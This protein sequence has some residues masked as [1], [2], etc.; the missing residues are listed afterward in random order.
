MPFVAFYHT[1]K[2]VVTLFVLIY[3]IKAILLLMGNKDTLGRFNKIVK[4]PEMVI[5]LLFFATGLVML[6]R[7]ANFN[8]LFAIKLTLVILSIPL[9]VVAYRK[10]NK[11]M[12]VFAVFM[13]LSAYGLAE[14]YKAQFAKKHEVTNVVTD[15][16]AAGYDLYKHGA[17]LFKVQC[18]VCHGED[19]KANLSGAKD[20][21]L[22]TKSDTEIMAIIKQGKNTMPKM[23]NIYNDQ[24]LK[25][26]VAYVK[27]FR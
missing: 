26:L 21:T 17:A 19:G 2:L 12:A 3:L 11:V 16:Q 15:P 14:T 23:A 13:L 22:S 25:A 18:T 10:G 1:H 7:I 8:T 27:A 20:L 4:I 24:E 6:S 5:S 9:A